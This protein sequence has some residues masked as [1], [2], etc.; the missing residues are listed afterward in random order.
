MPD[1]GPLPRRSGGGPAKPAIFGALIF[2]CGGS[3]LEE[4]ENEKEDTIFIAGPR[5]MSKRK[6]AAT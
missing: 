2:W 6:R 5:E 4:D 3:W 1:Q